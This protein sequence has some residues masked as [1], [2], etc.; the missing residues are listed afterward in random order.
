VQ[1]LATLLPVACRVF[2][3][4]SRCAVEMAHRDTP[5]TSST[6]Q[7]QCSPWMDT[8]E[9]PAGSADHQAAAT[10]ECEG[11]IRRTLA[12]WAES[13]VSPGES[14]VAI[15]RTAH[16][17]LR[18]R[19]RCRRLNQQIDAKCRRPAKAPIKPSNR[20][21]SQFRSDGRSGRHPALQPNVRFGGHTA[22]TFGPPRLVVKKR[23][24]KRPAS[25]PFIRGIRAFSAI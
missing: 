1:A 8:A 14:N 2:Q 15:H 18:S 11:K 16:R 21:F 25:L 7:S 17:R 22:A 5:Y 3:R 20:E 10:A 19:S 24:L 6:A 4:S 12:G 9:L 23:A 13:T